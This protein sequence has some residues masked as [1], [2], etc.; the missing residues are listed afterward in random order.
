M[1][2]AGVSIAPER[3]VRE[4][5]WIDF[6]VDEAFPPPPVAATRAAEVLDEVAAFEVVP[7]SPRSVPAP[8][9]SP[10]S[11]A[12]APRA[13]G[14]TPRPVAVTPRPVAAT[15]RAVA[16]TPRPVAATPLSPR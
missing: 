13:V 12:A 6:G 7:R 10:R 14:A 1:R 3:R 5:A 15:P 9:R 16:A 11:V 4:R 2:Q 8:P